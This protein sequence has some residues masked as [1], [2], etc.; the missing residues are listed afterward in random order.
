VTNLIKKIG[1]EEFNKLEEA[2]KTRKFTKEEVKE[3]IETYK[4]KVKEYE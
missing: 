3:I 1:E 4:K 2:N